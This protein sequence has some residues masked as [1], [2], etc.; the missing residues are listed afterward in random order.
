[1]GCCVWLQY[2][3]GERLALRMIFAP[4][5]QF[6]EDYNLSLN[7]EYNNNSERFEKMIEKGLVCEYER[8]Y[9][10]SDVKLIGYDYK[11]YNLNGWSYHPVQLIVKSRLSGVIW[12]KWRCKNKNEYFVFNG[13][14]QSNMERLPEEYC[15]CDD[16]E[17]IALSE[18]YAQPKFISNICDSKLIKFIPNSPQTDLS[19]YAFNYEYQRQM[20][21]LYSEITGI[22]DI[23]K[24]LVFDMFAV[25]FALNY[26][27]Y[28]YAESQICYKPYWCAD[29]KL[30]IIIRWKSNTEEEYVSPMADINSED[31][32]FEFSP[33]IPEEYEF[34]KFGL[35]KI[36]DKDLI[37]NYIESNPHRK[38]LSFGTYFDVKIVSLN[39]PDVDMLIEFQANVT[40]ETLNHFIVVI[41]DFVNNYNTENECK[42]HYYEVL[43]VADNTIRLFIDFGSANE[44]A[45]GK[46]M[47]ILHRKIND[48]KLISVN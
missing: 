26:D 31:V 21:K 24:Y 36:A 29:R 42:I 6:V 23:G 25:R 22:S 47:S 11:Q 46:L 28:T 45:F 37:L 32:M 7:L 8:I 43:K 4:Y 2:R 40:K 35:L 48:I 41:D 20:T 44:Y 10:K 12:I 15:F 39:Y 1:M 14:D 5:K 38:P 13:S 3:G 33:I 9:K 16:T 19:S 34:A 17:N 18:M 30:Y 27:G